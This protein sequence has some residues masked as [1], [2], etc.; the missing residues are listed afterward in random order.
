MWMMY[1]I[2]NNRQGDLIAFLRSF[3]D[4]DVFPRGRAVP[5][6]VLELIRERYREWVA[7]GAGLGRAIVRPLTPEEWERDREAYSAGLDGMDSARS[8][9]AA[10][11][12]QQR[13]VME[14]C[15]LVRAGFAFIVANWRTNLVAIEFP[16]MAAGVD[17]LIEVAIPLHGLGWKPRAD[18]IVS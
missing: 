3:R 4:G 17:E 9:V 8:S 13:L 11:D 12:P 18:R 14:A 5:L 1:R 6:R 10:A 15:Q 2:E 16:G 7:V